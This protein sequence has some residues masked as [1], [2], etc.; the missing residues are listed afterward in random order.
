MSQDQLPLIPEE[1]FVPPADFEALMKLL[2]EVTSIGVV[3]DFLRSKNLAHSAGS[4]DELREK[5]LKRALQAGSVTMDELKHLLAEAEE[6]G[7][8]HTFL[9]KCTRA[10]AAPF[11]DRGKVASVAA[12]LGLEASLGVGQVLDQPNEPHIASI[13][14]EEDGRGTSLVLKIVE[15]RT[16]HKYV[17]E[18]I[19]G[20]KLLAEWDISEAR[21]VNVVRLF[22]FGVLE[23]RIAS[24]QNSTRY[25]GDVTRVLR[26]VRPFLQGLHMDEFSLG[27]T[28]IKLWENRKDYAEIVR[29]SQQTLRNAAGSTLSGSARSEEKDIRN[30]KSLS[31]GLG[32][33][34]KTG[35]TYCES[36][37]IYWI[38]G[39]D[40]LPSKEIH[41]ILPELRNEFAVPAACSKQ[42]Y[43]YVFDQLRALSD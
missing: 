8:S 6:F 26:L 7:R 22:S 32:A 2:S 13:R 31:A 34:W 41:L 20:K 14:L 27:K 15:K 9:Y 4:W 18:R 28:K 37:N 10:A 24:H 42:D 19:E 21:A 33:F 23:V 11:L 17:G 40:A 38:A 39:K 29:F 36:S 30:D 16:R 3:S 25:D 43:E 1:P 35:E 12:G 5:R